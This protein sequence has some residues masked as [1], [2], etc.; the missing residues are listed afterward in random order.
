METKRLV[1]YSF[2]LREHIHQ[3]L[4]DAA[5]ERK[6]TSMV[7]DAITMIIENTGPFESGYK[8][9]IRD[10]IQAVEA[11]E[12]IR[13]IAFGGRPISENLLSQLEMMYEKT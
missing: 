9:G 12:D 6:A 10:A 11:D 2:H 5:K 13:K 1:P 7:R 3:A 8:K 4:K